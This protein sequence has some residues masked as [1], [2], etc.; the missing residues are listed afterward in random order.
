MIPLPDRSQLWPGKVVAAIVGRSH[1]TDVARVRLHPG[2]WRPP[3]IAWQTKIGPTVLP[4]NGRKRS[5]PADRVVVLHGEA[6]P[7]A[8][9]RVDDAALVQGQAVAGIRVGRT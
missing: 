3:E 2:R 5:Q 9:G 7:F 1:G 8:V 4:G 6:P